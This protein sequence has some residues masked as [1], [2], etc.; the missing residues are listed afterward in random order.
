MT[1][2]KKVREIVA[3]LENRG[4]FDRAVAALI[5]AGFERAD[6][7]VLSSHQLTT[8]PAAKASRMMRH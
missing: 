3:L 1:Q 4:D 7:S 6:L 8:P 2:N 5:R